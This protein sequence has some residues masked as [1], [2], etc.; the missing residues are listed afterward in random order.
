M[1]LGAYLLAGPTGI[2]PA[3]AETSYRVSDQQTATS[4]KGTGIRVEGD[5]MIWLDTMP[6]G[7]KQIFHKN[8]S[9]GAEK[10]IT[11]ALSHKDYAEVSGTH[12]VWADKRNHDALGLKWDI[13]SYDLQS[14]KETKLNTSAGQHVSPSIDG[15]DVVWYNPDN[16][17]MFH[18]DLAGGKETFLGKGRLPQAAGGKVAFKNV[19]NGGL[20]MY[21]LTTGETR[22][23]AEL[24]GGHYVS[25]F[26]FNGDAVV[27]KQNS[28]N[29]EIKYAMIPDVNQAAPAAISLTELRKPDKE[30]GT[31][32]IGD[33]MAVWLESRDGAAQIVGTS[34]KEASVKAFTAGSKDQTIYGFSGDRLLVKGNGDTLSYK[35]IVATEGGTQPSQPPFNPGP[36]D[37]KQGS[38]DGA[39]SKPA[40]DKDAADRIEKK[41]GPE[42]GTLAMPD[43]SLK[44]IIAPDS[45]EGSSLVSLRNFP[46]PDFKEKSSMKLIGKP[47]EISSEQVFGK[48]FVL[49]ASFA[50]DSILPRQA[51]KLAI[52]RY[53][54][55]SGLWRIVGGKVDAASGEATVEGRQAGTYALFLNEVSF[56]D[57][58]LHWA[59]QPIEALASR[60]ILNGM[61]ENRF[62]PDG[63]L[64][65]AQFTKML[66]EAA[67]L[68]KVS[69]SSTSTFRDATSAHWAYGWIESAVKAGLA[70]GEGELFE[71]ENELTR[72]QM[73][74]M[75]VRAVGKT[76]EALALSKDEV[77][78]I[79]IHPDAANVSGWAVPYVAMALKLGLVEGDHTGV[80]PGQTSTRA[81]AAA[82]IYRLLLQQQ[83][84]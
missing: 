69:G 42:G 70:E 33:K 64:T 79:F 28:P 5:D 56:D 59:Q 38:A 6:D 65:R 1:V 30:Y 31:I 19:Y 10:Q 80:N 76:Q 71:P 13:Y 67:G 72:E 27:W 2:K 84:I 35:T 3:F 41:I 73:M 68:E 9:T 25:A 61:D 83:K 74:T 14:G 39:G 15:N 11:E 50:P 18:Y 20:S 60:H 7:S 82:V 37:G 8:I 12:I 43:L 63:K 46:M 49:K 26:A 22:K 51:S 40:A 47:W 62:E 44:M 75:L 45:W 54:R 58:K 4:L 57:I 55:Q 52:Y 77:R 48:S 23:L 29:Q 24:G 34:V 21:D 53:D 32:Q 78:S 36:N 81:Q 66:V 16:Y 17:E